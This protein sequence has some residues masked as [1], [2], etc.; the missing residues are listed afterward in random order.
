MAGEAEAARVGQ[1]VG[2]R[3]QRVDGTLQG[4]QRGEHRRELA[5]RQQ[6]GH[7]GEAQGAPRDPLLDHATAFDVPY[8][9]RRD[10]VRAQRRGPAPARLGVGAVDAGDEAE[11][12]ARGLD[13]HAVREASLHLG[14]PG[15]RQ[16][17]GVGRSRDLHGAV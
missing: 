9:R 6:T 2:V 5:K 1:A 3:E 15:G 16:T 7:V 11:R 17:E 12:S 14:G 4:A 8:D 10:A 13:A